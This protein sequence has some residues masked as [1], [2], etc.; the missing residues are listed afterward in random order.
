MIDHYDQLYTKGYA[1]KVILPYWVANE[2]PPYGTSGGHVLSSVLVT[3]ITHDL[4]TSEV[5][6]GTS[7]TSAGNTFF[8][9][10]RRNVIV[11]VDRTN[12]IRQIRWHCTRITD[13]RRRHRDHSALSRRS[14]K[15]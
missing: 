4:I 5:T 8:A 2:W 7:I 12:K 13:K 10:I 9:D 1:V 11:L 3:D 6:L 15:Q 14:N